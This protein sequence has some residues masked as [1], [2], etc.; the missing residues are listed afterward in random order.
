MYKSFLKKY[1]LFRLGA[2]VI[3]L[4][5]FLKSSGL[6]L[7]F[8]IFGFS[9]NK[10]GQSPQNP[11]PMQENIRA[12]ERITKKE[13]KGINFFIENVLSKKV[14]VFIP[15][16]NLNEKNFNLLIHFNGAGFVVKYAAENYN[17]NI[18]SAAVNLGAGSKVYYD[19]FNDVSLFRKLIDS[20]KINCEKKLNKNITFDRIILSGFSAGYGA[21]KHLLNDYYNEINSIL[22]LDGLHAGYIPEGKVLFEGGKIDSS[23]LENFI[24][25]AK[26]ASESKKSKRFL[27]THSEIFPGTYVSTTEAADFIIKK[28]DLKMNPV[29]K[30]GPLGMQLLGEIKKNNFEILAFAG[31]TAPDHIDHLHGLFYFLNMLSNM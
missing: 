24:K 27:F 25:F 15:E 23:A 14:E 13:F 19:E 29:L 4:T 31:N 28:L 20:I 7:F 17:K 11:S 3:N 5:F 26:D 12:H 10:S 6:I 21:I 1:N 16:K 2:N 9:Q 18:I 22:L 8:L 30:W